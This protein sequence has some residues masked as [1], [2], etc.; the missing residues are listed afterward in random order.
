[1]AIEGASAASTSNEHAPWASWRIV[2]PSYFRAA[3]LSLLAGRVFDE[4]DKPVWGRPKDPASSRRVLISQRLARRLFPDGN[5]VGRGV[6]LWKSQSNMPAEI[7]G[8]VGDSRERGPVAG[9][10]L[11]VYLPYGE[12]AVPNEFIVHTSIPPLSLLPAVRSIVSDLNPE[13]P[14][15]DIRSFEDVVSTSV[16][17]QRFTAILLAVFS[18]FALLLAT[19]GLYSVLSFTVNRRAAEIGLR[20]ALGAT[21]RD[22]MRMTLRQGFAPALL[23]IAF[24]SIGAWWLSRFIATLLFE[25]KPFDPPTYA[26]VA[27]LVL[28]TAAA[29][30]YL[31]GRR[32][33]KTD[34]TAALR[35][36]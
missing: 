18:G 7:I 25:V 1:M 5:A 19:M 32:A 15:S 2:T 24:G 31:P 12:I 34:P 29:G 11:T 6:I 28:L 13:L 36:E 4:N 9:A 3:G 26:V 35:L 21:N 20:V 16:A 23:G 27:A 17:P 8:V 30:S 14:V 10:A 33:V 22:I